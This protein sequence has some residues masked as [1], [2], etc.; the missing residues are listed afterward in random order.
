MPN[1]TW[2]H[3]RS[4]RTDGWENKPANFEWLNFVGGK[5][6]DL[7]RRQRGRRFLFTTST[8]GDANAYTTRKPFEE[9]K[10]M[11]ARKDAA[12]R[13]GGP[14]PGTYKGGRRKNKRANEQRNNDAAD[15]YIQAQQA[16]ANALYQQNNRANY[17]AS[18]NSGGN[19]GFDD[20]DDA[21]PPPKKRKSGR[22]QPASTAGNLGS[23]QQT[24][25][26]NAVLRTSARQQAIQANQKKKAAQDKRAQAARDKK[27]AKNAKN[28]K[29]KK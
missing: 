3:F 12:K 24:N 19:G 11:K 21:P 16:A 7:F 5:C 25:T 23:R 4:D 9:A 15:A 1:Q 10:M 8:R 29:R 27:N 18:S 26:F 14:N 20:D 6:S 28:A 13:Y 22:R 2:N 17:A